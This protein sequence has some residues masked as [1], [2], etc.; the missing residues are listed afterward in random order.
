MF[1][2]LELERRSLVN[3]EA[4]FREMGQYR[5][6]RLNARE[7]SCAPEDLPLLRFSLPAKN[8]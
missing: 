6:L 1:L 7:S 2:S 4:G 3:F 5:E 8:M